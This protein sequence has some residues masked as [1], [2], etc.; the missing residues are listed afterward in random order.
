MMSIT[1]LALLAAAQAG[2]AGPAAKPPPTVSP[3]VIVPSPPP[4]RDERPGRVRGPTR[5]ATPAPLRTSARPAMPLQSL[6]NI[7]DY[8]PSAL[9]EREQGRPGFRLTVGPDGRVT[10]CVILVSSGSPALDSTTCRV[11]R[12]RARFTPAVDSNGRPVED[13]YWGEI[14]WRIASQ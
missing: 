14:A 8:P 5:G 1:V 13:L 3:P 4:P 6:I 11:L 12:N 9:R 10:G 7:A 2:Q